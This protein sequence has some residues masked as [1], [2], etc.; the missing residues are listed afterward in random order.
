MAN[1]GR[2]AGTQTEGCPLEGGGALRTERQM[3]E[4]ILGT[5]R[6]DA[7]VRAVIMNGSRVN[8]RAPRDI[9]QDYDIVY[10]VTSVQDLLG[11][12]SWIDRFGERIIM[13]TPDAMGNPPGAAAAAPRDPDDPF[14]FLMLFRDGNRIDL[15]LYPHNRLAAMAPD[16]LTRVLLDKDG[17]LPAMPPPSDADYLPKP[18]TAEQYADCCNEFWW[19]STYVAKGLWRREL[20]YAQ[21]HH[22]GPVRAMLMQMLRWYIAL[23]HDFTADPGKFGKYFE[24]HLEA[25]WWQRFVATYAGGDYEDLWRALFAACALFSDAATAVGQ[26]FGYT[27]PAEEEQRVTTH[28]RQVRALPRDAAHIY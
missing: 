8:P 21:E 6:A 9:F 12:R 25:A 28:L 20:P 24:R 3:L 5:A 2:D 22:S 4:L 10:A 11:D 16:S 7:R 17:A 1:L 19:V 15:T 13:E 14:A 26:H 18:P 27:Y 23:R